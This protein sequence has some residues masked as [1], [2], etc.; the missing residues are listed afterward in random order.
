MS[1]DDIDDVMAIRGRLVA[2]LTHTPKHVYDYLELCNSLA[3][4]P[5]PRIDRLNLMVGFHDGFAM[6]IQQALLELP[7]SE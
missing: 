2:I 4:E 6:A 7:Q 1:V 5:I 3:A